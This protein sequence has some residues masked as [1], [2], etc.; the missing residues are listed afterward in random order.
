M[1]KE[2][3]AQRPSSI[4]DIIHR[5]KMFEII[6]LASSA[7]YQIKKMYKCGLISSNKICKACSLLE[8][9]KM[10][11]KRVIEYEKIKMKT[12]DEENNTVKK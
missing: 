1:I 5:G 2:L 12:L 6:K 9:L 4:I 8:K 7:N 11:T 10:K 3:E